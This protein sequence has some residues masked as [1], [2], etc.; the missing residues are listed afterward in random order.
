MRKKS[1]I[2]TFKVDGALLEEL[3]KVPNRSA[4]IRTAVLSALRATCPLCQGT[5]ILSASQQR[6]WDRFAHDH[7][8]TECDDCH[9]L[10]LVCEHEAGQRPGRKPAGRKPAAG[11]VKAGRRG[12]TR[13]GK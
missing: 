6:H 1:E 13:R 5:G 2:V 12:R 7:A 3:R 9:E 11:A 8:V 10:Y 4:F